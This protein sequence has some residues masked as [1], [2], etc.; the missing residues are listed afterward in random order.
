MAVSDTKAS[1]SALPDIA[2]E[3]PEYIRTNLEDRAELL[4]TTGGYKLARQEA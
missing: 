3:E 1:F 2:A 4:P